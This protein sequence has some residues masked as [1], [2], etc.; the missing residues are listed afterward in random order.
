MNSGEFAN[1]AKL[2]IVK[3]FIIWIVIIGSVIISRRFI[4]A[5]G[6]KLK[7][8]WMTLYHWRMAASLFGPLA[9]IMFLFWI[10]AKQNN[11]T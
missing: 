4:Q 7:L 10:K 8:D 2:F 5:K 11:N 6:K 3:S 9:V 1:I